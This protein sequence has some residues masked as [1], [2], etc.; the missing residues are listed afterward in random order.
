MDF[1]D[2]TTNFMRIIK[3]NF[4]EGIQ[5]T[6]TLQKHRLIS[7]YR[8]GQNLLDYLVKSKVQPLIKLKPKT[9]TDYLYTMQ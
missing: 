4:N 5:N 2:S 6:Q 9:K 1:S 8:R 7:A 3:N